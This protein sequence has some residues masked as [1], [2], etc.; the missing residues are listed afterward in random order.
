MQPNRLA[1]SQAVGA[2]WWYFLLRGLLLLGLGLFMIFDPGLTVVA[3]AQVIA[4]FLIIDGLLVLATG[5]TGQ[6]ESRFWSVLR[7]LLMLV[8]GLFIFLQPALVASIAMKT[9][10]FIVAPFV[11]LSGV[12][13]IV[14]HFKQEDAKSGGRSSLLGGLLTALIGLLLILAPLF[15]GELIVRILGILVLLMSFP[16]LFLAFNFRKLKRQIKEEAP[17]TID[18]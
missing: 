12:M 14:N 17:V 2:V 16:L 13:E 6:A 1:A 5:F 10:L 9:V 3:F 8:G 15:F 18:V 11:I 4:V 7:G